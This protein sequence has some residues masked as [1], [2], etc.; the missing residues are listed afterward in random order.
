MGLLTLANI[1]SEIQRN[2]GT[3]SDVDATQ[4]DR[5]IDIAQVRMA[6]IKAWQELNI[7]HDFTIVNT[8]N[9]ETDRINT[10]GLPA[11]TVIRKVYSLRIWATSAVTPR[12]LIQINAEKFDE[13]VPDVSYYS[14]DTP[15]HYILWQH[16]KIETFPVIKE[17]TQ[18]RMRFGKMPTAT[19]SVSGGGAGF[20]DFKYQDDAVINLATAI[21]FMA[22]QRRDKAMEFFA[23]FR[24]NLGEAMNLDEEEV[25]NLQAA[26]VKG[27]RLISTRGYDDPFV[28]SIR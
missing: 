28:R 21:G 18:F 7:V 1:R 10:I 13:I 16:G 26:F 19:A 12:K 14:R 5:W 20:L 17:D 6:R 3:R 2:L 27:D 4:T 8:G 24:E 9:I 25:D 23:F 11:S 15:T 22:L